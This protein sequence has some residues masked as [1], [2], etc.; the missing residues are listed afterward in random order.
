VNP[1]VEREAAEENEGAPRDERMIW[2]G[3][4]LL[5]VGLALIAASPL[6][7]RSVGAGAAYD[8]LTPFAG[9][10]LFAAG[11]MIVGVGLR[12]RGSPLVGGLAA[13]LLYEVAGF[14][15]ALTSQAI[16]F[17][18]PIGAFLRQPLALLGFVQM[19]PIGLMFAFEVFGWGPR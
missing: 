15:A 7:I 10:G 19:W 14:A 12:P 18:E 6:I 4:G 3:A 2:W 17:H 5:V 9:L 1:E 16:A 11:W 13:F 8:E